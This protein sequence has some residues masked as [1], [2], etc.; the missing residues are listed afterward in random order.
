[1]TENA[2]DTQM[3]NG[4]EIWS[5]ESY[6]LSDMDKAQG[7]N[8]KSVMSSSKLHDYGACLTSFQ[9]LSQDIVLLDDFF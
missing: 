2:D 9:S 4:Y 6:N 8:Q 1:M 3:C 5:S 7:L